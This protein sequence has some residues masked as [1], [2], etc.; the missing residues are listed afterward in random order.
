ML[1]CFHILVVQYIV[2]G[3]GLPWKGIDLFDWVGWL[4]CYSWPVG[5]R[6]EWGG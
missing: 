5:R 2:Y 3:N 4:A 6:P 1:H